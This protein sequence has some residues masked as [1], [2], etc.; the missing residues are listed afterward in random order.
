MKQLQ[1]GASKKPGQAAQKSSTQ[2]KNKLNAA[3]NKA[4]TGRGQRE[5]DDDDD[6]DDVD[7]VN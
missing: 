4:R 5:D 7:I 2:A 3:F 6:V 1:G